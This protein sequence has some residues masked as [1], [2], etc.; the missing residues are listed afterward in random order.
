[1]KSKYSSELK[2]ILEKINDKVHYKYPNDE[3]HKNG[4]LID[5]CVLSP[6]EK[7]DGVPYWDVIDLIDFPDEPKSKRIN[8]R[9]GYYRKPKDRLVWGSQTTITEPLDVWRKL[10][11]KTANEKIWFRKLLEEVIEEVKKKK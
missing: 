2:Q 3:G 11:I 1:M 10:L 9:I 5:R 8:M 6:D 7:N 4:T